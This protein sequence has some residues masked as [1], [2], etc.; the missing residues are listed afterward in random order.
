M[1]SK[2]EIDA[3]F[4]TSNIRI[5]VTEFGTGKDST[6]SF[7]YALLWLE[8]NWYVPEPFLYQICQQLGI[9]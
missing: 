4:F 9:D 1:F 2:V 5:S 7:T 8:V 3:Q 6:D